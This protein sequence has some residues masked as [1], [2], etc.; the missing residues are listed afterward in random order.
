MGHIGR[1][2]TIRSEGPIGL[3]TFQRNSYI[4]LCELQFPP[5]K[6]FVEE[7]TN[8]S[9]HLCFALLGFLSPLVLRW[10]GFL[11]AR[12]RCQK[13]SH[14]GPQGD[15]SPWEDIKHLSH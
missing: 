14:V 6:E 5:C 2:T 1:K 12:R 13:Q 9:Q 7:Y 8:E 11:G 3:A 4:F 10:K 15:A